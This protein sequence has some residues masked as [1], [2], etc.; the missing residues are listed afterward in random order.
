MTHDE[1]LRAAVH[2]TPWANPVPTR[3]YH[4]VVIGAGTA[5]L[6]TAAGAAGLGARVALIE[7]HLMGG[8]CLNV[9]CVPS[10]G[11]IASA[12][13]WSS[14][15]NAAAA[16]HGPAVVGEG[17]FTAVMERM[18]R[19]RADI[20]PVDGAERFQALGV[21]V[22]F[23]DAA[24]N[25]PNAITV[26][27]QTLRFR[28]AVIATGA[29]A[30]V[31][32]IPGLRDVSY[33]TNE[34]LF[35]L[36]ECP[37]HL[38]VLGGGPIGCEMAQAF[39]RFGARVTLIDRADRLL[40]RDDVDASALV[41]RALERDGVQL[42]LG[43][44]IERVDA[45][46][47]QIVVRGTKHDAPLLVQGD[48]LL[49][50]IGRTANVEGLGLERAGVSYSANGVAVD[51]RLRTTN[52]NVYACGD[53]CSRLQFTHAA[54]FQ[55]RTVIQNALFFGRKRA[56]QLV[57]PWAT[58][59]SPEVAHV[60]HT[61]K[62]ARDADVAVQ[63]FTVPMHDVDRALLDGETDG[64]AR[65]HVRQGTDT[66]VGATVVGAH[67]SELLAEVTLCMTNGLGLSAIGA[68][69]HPYPTQGDAIRKCA[70]AWRKTKLT[71]GVRAA[72]RAWFRCLS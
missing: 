5:G 19:L 48:R 71:P 15:R 41:Q 59:T 23:G 28:R 24:F 7:R 21:D 47:A 66:I 67:A 3:R 57:I 55:A 31:P 22:Y 6:V 30:V 14:A 8:D 10:K 9:G 40:P 4:L 70:D 46:G 60:G 13:Q 35:D 37:E 25:S 36:T 58:Y 69:I 51:D 20:A 16:Y 39:A 63:T 64:F 44:T 11:L 68:T 34:T 26:G 17:D 27:D 42:R 29:R 53:V 18:R 38:V 56:S 49:V 12:R 1:R 2:P 61:A 33:L 45:D 52:P 32:P 50:A 72:F 62:S 54:D 65:I 43:A